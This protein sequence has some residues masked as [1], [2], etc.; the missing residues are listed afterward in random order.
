MKRTLLVAD[1]EYGIREFLYELFK[2][3]YDVKLANDGKEAIA[4]FDKE[5]FDVALIDLRMPEVSGVEVLEY[6]KE[7]NIDTIP[8]VI[9][10]DRDIDHAVEAMKMG[11]YDYIT[12]PMDYKKLTITIHNAI[13]KKGLEERI[14]SLERDVKGPL[15]FSNI[16]SQSKEM[17]S[18]FNN[19]ENVLNNDATVLI[20]GESGTG[21]ELIARAIHFNGNRAQKPFI[22]VDCASIPESLIETELFGYEKGSFTGAGKTTR[23]KFELADEGTLFLDEISNISMDAQAKLLRVIQER[24]FLRIGGEKR[25]SVNVRIISASNKDLKKMIHDGTFRED[26]YYRL[27][28]IPIHLPP[29][30]ER[31][32]DIPLLIQHFLKIFNERY[33]KKALFDSGT[34]KILMDYR[35]PGNVREL[36]NVIN[37]II[38]TSDNDVIL[39]EMLPVEIRRAGLSIMSGTELLEAD[40][41][42]DN[43]EK[44]HIEKLLKKHEYNI[45]TVAEI[46][47]VTRKT[48]YAKME[49]FGLQKKS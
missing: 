24:E 11:A 9:T 26:L 10:A 32:E 39:P 33:Q 42:L 8:I 47:G 12:K 3:T 17:R 20:Y 31:K 14:D 25:I 29:V 7:K 41:T 40:I 49:K 18:V 34:L 5:V 45:S 21:K 48:L 6:I 30:R 38:L 46:L 23:G 43:L 27:N 16:I 22:P 19:I 35:W 1:D 44:I 2:E 13:E 37:R 36:E 15:F 28:V 4:L